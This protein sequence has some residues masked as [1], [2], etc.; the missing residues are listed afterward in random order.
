MRL[1]A[2]SKAGHIVALG[3][4]CW[5]LFCQPYASNTW[6]LAIGMTPEQTAAALGV[7]LTYDSG[8]PGSEVYLARDFADIPG[9]FPADAV[10]ALQF[11]HGHLTGWKANWAMRRPWIVY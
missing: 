4:L 3:C 1:I 2:G 5:A 9:L 11:R 7:P 10:L 8:P 6:P